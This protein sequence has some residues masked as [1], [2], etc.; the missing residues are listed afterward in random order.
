MLWPIRV[1]Q[2]LVI[3]R[4]LLRLIGELRCLVKHKWLESCSEYY[5][6]RKII[7]RLD[8]LVIWLDFLFRSGCLTCVALIDVPS[9]RLSLLLCRRFYPH[10]SYN[11]YRLDYVCLTLPRVLNNPDKGEDANYLYCFLNLSS[12]IAIKP[13]D[14]NLVPPFFISANYM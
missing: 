2:V 6:P 9:G 11:C 7:L 13:G 8:T 4:S 14:F 10:A 3:P 12:T 1:R 5:T